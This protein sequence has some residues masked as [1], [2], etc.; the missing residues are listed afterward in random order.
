MRERRWHPS[1]A[2][3]SFASNPF[4]SSIVVLIIKRLVTFK[5]RIQQEADCSEGQTKKIFVWTGEEEKNVGKGMKPTPMTLMR[6]I[7][8][9][10]VKQFESC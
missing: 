10:I 1:K 7:K 6:P 8:R 3:P 2:G 9:A 5:R 4:H